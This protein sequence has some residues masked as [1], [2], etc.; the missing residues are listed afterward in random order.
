MT[1]F[2]RRLFTL[3]LSI[4][5]SLALVWFTSTGAIM[6]ADEPA[7]PA[8]GE[9]PKGQRVYS[10]GHSFHVFMPNILTQ[11][12]HLAGIADHQQVGLSSIGGSYVKQ[13]WDA[14]GDKFRSKATLE[15]GKLDV[16]TIAP[17]FL[18]DEGIENFVHLASEKCPQIRVLVQE[19]WLPFDVN[20]NF[21]NGQPPAPDR[22]VFDP[23]KLQAEHDQYFHG[24]DELVKTLNEK[25]QGKPAVF[26]VPVGQAVL[27]LRKKIADGT[28]PGLTKQTD[29]FTDSIGHARPPL[30]VLV[31][32]C[33]YGEI[34]GR[35]PVG[36]P[37]PPALGR[38]VDEETTAKLNHLLQEIA[39][40]AVTEH[41]LSA[42]K[43]K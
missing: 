5:F 1:M 38:V 15:S 3:T 31:A 42:V 41:P 10:I 43:A 36:L 35:S 9:V 16:L 37:V 25:Y 28:V 11:I 4:S 29:L 26:V 22:N 14:D 13:H 17:L 7:K 33:Y 6:H 21:R 40:T 30:E 12:A 39:W 19:F 20:V 27:A 32:Y 8:A 23:Q 24:I 2:A 18:P 34:Y